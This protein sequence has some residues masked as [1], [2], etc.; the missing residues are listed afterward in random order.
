MRATLPEA[1]G[2]NGHT[3][4]RRDEIGILA[5]TFNQMVEQ[6]SDLYR[7]LE[8]K[9]E[10]RT[11]QLRTASEVG[12]LA[13]SASNREEIIERAVKLVIDRFGYSFAS[14]FLLDQVGSSAVL[15]A[16][17]S[18]SGEMKDQLG[19]RIVISP[20]S[21]IGW[22]AKNNQPRV[23]SD[24]SVSEFPYNSLIFSSS[25]SEVAIPISVGSQVLGV[26]EVQS[27]NSKGFEPESI[28][29]LL[30]L[31]NQIANGL[32]NLRLLEATQINLEETDLL[33]RTSR[34]I[35]LT[36]NETDMVRVIRESLVQ[37]PYVS[38]LFSV[39]ENYLGII[40]IT[41]PRNL[42][43]TA[44]TQGI[45]LPLLRIPAILERQHQVVIDDLSRPTD[46][47]VL[48]SFFS[49]RGCR[50]ASIFSIFDESRLTKILVLG[51][52]EPNPDD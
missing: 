25:Q 43:A 16:A 4:R 11:R 49:R 39:E 48:L 41:D 6:I 24:F 3:I 34:Q 20:D 7:S 50:S 36:K 29:V 44:S 42:G 47:D 13:T 37:T 23:I 12:Q 40:A 9:V 14:I 52:R 32:Q 31:C 38:G 19:Y 45:T 22:V 2:P 35:S 21:L 46:Y 27:I 30:T 26:F 28:S 1:I 17:Y 18:Q 5:S 15:Q 51:S 33:Y 8:Q 10:E